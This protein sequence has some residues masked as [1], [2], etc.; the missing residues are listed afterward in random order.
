MALFNFLKT[1][2]PVQFDFKP[3]F[4]D[5]AKE[6][7]EKR[8]K[9]V[10][11]VQ[12]DDIEGIKERIAS[13]FRRPESLDAIHYRRKMTMRSNML[14]IALIFFLGLLV[15]LFFNVLIPYLARQGTQ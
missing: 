8:L 15:L 13:G 11:D 2:K 10:K 7:R 6:A 5:S 4:Y 1:I 9:E 3:R 14:V 12:N